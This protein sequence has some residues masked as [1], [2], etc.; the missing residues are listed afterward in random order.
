MHP[1]NRCVRR[2]KELP[3][4]R[5]KHAGIRNH[6]GKTVNRLIAVAF[7]PVSETQIKNS[8]VAW[9]SPSALHVLVLQLPS[10][11]VVIKKSRSSGEGVVFSD[12]TENIVYFIS[13][14]AGRLV[15]PWIV[16]GRAAYWLSMASMVIHGVMLDALT[17][18]VAAGIA[19]GSDRIRISRSTPQSCTIR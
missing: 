1:Y 11:T 2:N 4:T 3:L 19:A 13:W 12:V 16:N 9:I 8:P 5:Y 6:G 7:R 17:G 15:V 10:C 18:Q 14:P